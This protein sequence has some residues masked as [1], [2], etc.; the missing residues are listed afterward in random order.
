MKMKKRNVKFIAAALVAVAGLSV[1][2]KPCLA[3][4]KTPDD[5]RYIGESTDESHRR[6]DCNGDGRYN[7]V[8]ANIIL[9]YCLYPQDY[10]SHSYMDVNKDKKISPVDATLLLLYDLWLATGSY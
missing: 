10:A 5:L 4:S 6:G 9:R 8:D 2:S 7:A 3:W 1:Y